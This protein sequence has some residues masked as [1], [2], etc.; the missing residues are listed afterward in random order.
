MPICSLAFANISALYQE[1]YRFFSL[2]LK[3]RNLK[4]T[5]IHLALLSAMTPFPQ[6]NVGEKAVRCNGFAL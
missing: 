4:V 5:D 3:F 6:N 2:L 1:A